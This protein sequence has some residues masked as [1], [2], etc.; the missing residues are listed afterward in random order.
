MGPMGDRQPPGHHPGTP[1]RWEHNTRLKMGVTV[2]QKLVSSNSHH[3]DRKTGSADVH[4][5][6]LRICPQGYTCCTSEMEENFANKSRSEFEAMMKEAG[7]SVQ[8]ILTAQHRS[9]DNFEEG[10]TFKIMALLTLS[11]V[12]IWSYCEKESGKE[13]VIAR[14]VEQE[15]QVVNNRSK[16]ISL[17][18]RLIT[19]MKCFYTK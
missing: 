9:F 15:I 5:E 16:E 2:V 1:L 7:R 14:K 6:H 4:G 17:T 18:F 11:T 10:Q 8:A 13:A 19:Q 3:T 12:I